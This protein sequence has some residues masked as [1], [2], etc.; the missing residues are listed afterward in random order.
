MQPDGDEYN[1]ILYYIVYDDVVGGGWQC[2][3]PGQTKGKRPGGAS[4]ATDVARSTRHRI[5]KQ[6][7]G[8]GGSK[9]GTA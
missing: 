1:T 5:N 8:G 7:E 6:L 4:V 2:K 3:F 9:R